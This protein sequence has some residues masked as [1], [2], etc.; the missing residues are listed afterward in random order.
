M[1]VYTEVLPD[2]EIISK[3][4]GFNTVVIVGCGSC[5]NE[6]LAFLNETLITKTIQKENGQIDTIR[7]EVTCEIER[8]RKTLEVYRHKVEQILIN[9][10]KNSVCTIDD[11]NIELYKRQIPI[12]DVYLTLCCPSGQM[13]LGEIIGNFHTILPI[14]KVVGTLYCHFEEIEGCQ[15]IIKEKSKILPFYNFI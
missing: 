8:I 6:S 10:G 1:G 14:M 15:K 11:N 12:A 7:Y 3:C 9:D 4:E 5:T 13:G 2:K